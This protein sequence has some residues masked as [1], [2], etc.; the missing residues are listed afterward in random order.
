ME[1]S[2]NI[3]KQQSSSTIRNTFSIDEGKLSK[4]ITKYTKNA[5]VSWEKMVFEPQWG[6]H[7]KKKKNAN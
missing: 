2:R 1:F 6:E 5:W 4:N 7:W 3:V